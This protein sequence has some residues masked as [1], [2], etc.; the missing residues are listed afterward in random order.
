MKQREQELN[1]NVFMKYAYLDWLTSIKDPIL[2][3]VNEMCSSPMTISSSYK[4]Q[5]MMQG[6]TNPLVTR[7][8]IQINK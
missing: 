6:I 2:E 5:I 8:R 1:K 3:V 7:A 4:A